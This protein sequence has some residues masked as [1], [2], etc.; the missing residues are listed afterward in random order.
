M[1]FIFQENLM[2]EFMF[3]ILLDKFIYTINNKQ[4]QANKLILKV[5]QLE[6]DVLILNL[7]ADCNIGQEELIKIILHR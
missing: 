7:S 1:K 4:I 6:M 5:L 3:L 2:Q